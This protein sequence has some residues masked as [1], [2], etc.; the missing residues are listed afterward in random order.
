[1]LYN[2]V[3]LLDRGS[4]ERVH[5]GSLRVLR[6]VG[7]RVAD[8]ECLNILKKTGA[9]V[10]EQ[11][12][13]V[14]LPAPMVLEALGQVTKSF[15]LMNANG[16]RF[17]MPCDKPRL[18]SRVKMPRILDY[19]CQE[20]RWPCH[21]DVVNLCRINNALPK[22]EFSYAVDYPSTDVPSEIDI[23]DTVGLLFAITGNP[24]VCAR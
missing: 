18:V 9:R 21:E 19:G 5:R 13:L 12:D 3:S 23:A 22:V 11:T 15:E 8:P 14:R 16:Y 10:D 7:V 4:L 17:S 20:A 6:N 2:A 24:G 1:M